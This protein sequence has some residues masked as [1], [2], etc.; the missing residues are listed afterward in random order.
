MKSK[1]KHHPFVIYDNLTQFQN[2]PAIGLAYFYN[3]RH[4]LQVPANQALSVLYLVI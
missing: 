1:T 3:F 4:F 2:F